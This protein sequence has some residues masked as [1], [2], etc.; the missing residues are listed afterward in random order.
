MP[1]VILGM[2]QKQRYFSNMWGAVSEFIFPKRMRA[3]CFF[4]LLLPCFFG[5]HMKQANKHKKQPNILV[6]FR[7]VSS[8]SAI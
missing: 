5:E 1:S 6:L 4:L 2:R 3:L 7:A 8:T